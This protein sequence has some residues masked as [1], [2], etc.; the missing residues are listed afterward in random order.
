MKMLEIVKSIPVG[1]NFPRAKKTQ[2]AAHCVSAFSEVFFN[3]I[4]CSINIIETF[5]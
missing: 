4:Q 5:G 2:R 3:P 1:M